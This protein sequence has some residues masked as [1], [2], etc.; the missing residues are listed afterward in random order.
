MLIIWYKEFIPPDQQAIK[1]FHLYIRIICIE[2]PGKYTKEIES[3]IYIEPKWLVSPNYVYAC[4]TSSTYLFSSTFLRNWFWWND[5]RFRVNVNK[6]SHSLRILFHSLPLQRT[7]LNDST[8]QSQSIKAEL[9]PKQWE[10]TSTEKGG[11]SAIITLSACQ[12]HSP[13]T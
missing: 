5:L 3:C 6:F 13:K 8:L 12:N 4:Y 2:K 1:N 11:K 10:S 7:E 9:K